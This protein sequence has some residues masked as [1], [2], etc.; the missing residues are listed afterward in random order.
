MTD[1]QHLVGISDVQ[2]I[3]L[4]TQD[5]NH[6]NRCTWR[7]FGIPAALGRLMNHKHVEGTY[8][9]IVVG[10]GNQRVSPFEGVVGS[11]VP[12]NVINPVGSV[13]VPKIN[14]DAPTEMMFSKD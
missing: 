9:L 10:E 8:S 5:G 12:S 4:R 13:V 11:V 7:S 14:E 6:M 3:L 2:V 1:Q